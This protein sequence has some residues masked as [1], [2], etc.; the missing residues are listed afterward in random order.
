MTKI[1]RIGNAVLG[2]IAL[3]IGVSSVQAQNGIEPRYEK[4]NADRKSIEV[5]G[6][7]SDW[8]GVPFISPLFMASDSRE[9]G[10][11]NKEIGGEVYSQFAEFAGGTWSG[12]DDH[13]TS[14]A[15]AWDHKG[16]Y[17]GIIVKDDEHEH[18][19]NNAWNGDGVQMGLTDP[20]RETVTHLYN[21]A[22]KD[23]YESGKVY[24]NGEAGSIADKE[25]GP[26]NYKVAMVRHDDTKTT[27]YEAL[28]T[29]DSFGFTEFAVG[30]QFGFGVCVND[31][32]KDTAG[33]KGWSGWGPHMIVFGKTAPD[34]A[35]VTLTGKE[36][37]GLFSSDFEDGEVPDGSSTAGVAEVLDGAMHITEAANG[38]NGGWTIDDFTDGATFTEFELSFR[39]H[40]TDSACCGD[41]D[42]TT[43]GHRPADGMSISIGNDLPDLANPAEEG[44]GEGI[45]ICFDTWDSGGGEAPAIDFFS[46]AGVDLQ[47]RQKFNGVTTATEDEKFKDEDGDYVWLWTQGEWADVKI[48]VLDGLLTVNYKGHD[49]ISGVSV[50]FDPLEGPSWL[51]AARTGGAN[52]THWID[53]LKIS[54]YASSGPLV[55]GFNTDAAGFS[56]SLT[57]ADGNGVV[58]DSVGVTLDG[59]AVDASASKADGVTTIKYASAAPFAQGSTHALALTYTDE[60]GNTKTVPLDFTVAPYALI[61]AG[62][63]ADAS[64]KGGSGFLVYATQVSTG[65]GVGN[66]H[67]NSWALAE[68]QI[69]GGFIDPDTEEPYLN[70]ADVDS[71]EGWSYFPEIVQVVNQNQDAPAEV[72]NFK[73]SN[74]YE[75]EPLTGIPGWGDSTDGVASEYIALLDLARGAYKLGV[76]SDDGF[77]A[78]IGANFGDLLAQQIGV[79]DG[80]RGSSDTVFEIFVD[81]PG[82]YPFRVSWW[83]GGGGA[84]IEI[85]SY[86]GGKKTLI[87]DPDVDGSIKAYTIKGAVVDES[88]TVRATTGRAKMIS[89]SPNAGDKLVKSSAIEVVI[90]NE[91]TSVK[92]DTVVVTLNGEAVEASVSKDGNLVTI[93]Y[94]PDGGLPV[95]LHTVGVSFEESNGAARGTEW[96]FN[97]PGVYKRD[98]DVPTEAQGG[99]TV[100]EYHGIGTTSIA[101]LM[102]ADKFPDSPDVSAIAPYFEW[103]QS[104]DI[105]VN[106]VG[107]V[108]DN[109]GWHLMGYIHPP[110]TGEYSFAVATDDNSQ[111]WLSTDS[112]PA[113]AVQ[114]TQE[115]TWQG[116]RNYQPTGDETTSA[117]VFLEAGK[118]YF[119][120]CFAKEGG[121]GDNMAVAW[122][123]PEDGPTDVD[124]GSLPISGE[125][126]SPFTWAGPETPA[127]GGVSPSGV[128]GSTDY[129][130]KVIISN[131]QSVKM[132]SFT[133]LDINGVSA[134]DSAET[135]SSGISS[136]I[137]ADGS[138]DAATE[139]NVSVS[140]ENSDGS[141]GSTSWS[142]MTAPHSE[143]SLYIETEDFNY[144][145]GEW[146][147]FEDTAGGGA[148]DGLEM[149]TDIDYHN[150]GNSSPL[151]RVSDD[152]HPGMADSM[153]DSNRGD[154]DMDIDFKMGW[155]D[156]GDWYN[157]TRDFPAKETYYNVIGRFSSGGAAVNNKL[158]IVSGDT[159]TVD[160]TTTD[161]GVFQGPATGGWDTMKFF[162]MTDSAGSLAVVKIGGETT[163]RLTKVSGNMDTQYLVF[164]PSAIQEYPPLL[165][166]YG[167]QGMSESAVT[168]TATFA[169]RELPLKSASVTVNGAAVDATVDVT[170]DG[171]SISAAADLAV[172]ANAD[173]VLTWVDSNGGESSHSWSF[174]VGPYS[175]DN[176]FVEAEDFNYDGGAH[177][178]EAS[179]GVKGLYDGISAVA[180][181]DYHNAD[182][183]T[184]ADDYRKGEDPNNSMAAHNDAGGIGVGAR[185][186]FDVATDYKIG[187]AAKGDWFTYTRDF[188]KG[189]Y[190]VFTRVSHG[191]AN[192]TIGGE[193]HF[194]SGSD[195]KDQTLTEIG[196]ARG[197]APGGWATMTFVQFTTGD[198][199]TRVALDGEQTIR[200]TMHSGDFQYLMLRPV[201]AEANVGDVAPEVPTISVVRNDNGT[202]TVTFTGKLQTAPTVNGPWQ[203]AGA[204]SPLTIPADAAQQ[205]GRASSE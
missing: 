197:P 28:F 187:W 170:D 39:L 67:G 9:T 173:V 159:T 79:F 106:P 61:D 53:D 18:A 149:V 150:A 70:E 192:E 3:L 42:D 122:S 125:F 181:V 54:I 155:N 156:D 24:K 78:T 167:P 75:D 10:K 97:V 129:T 1:N 40:M 20:E 145:G 19:A 193:L 85:F 48:S 189:V 25:K 99:L 50:S 91:G 165:G 205:Y 113:N 37:L 68:K 130:V 47:A 137:S 71:F 63:I 92:Q 198:E 204:P 35:L 30:Q 188:P 146:M 123:T 114:L 166:S 62:S 141:T 8:S 46:G 72:G 191:N 81:K 16:L 64:Q 203:D 176:F 23:G 180:D 4:Y 65:Q 74:G 157:Y 147:T 133:S 154:F 120:E 34:A 77:S 168:I 29:P 101:V 144:D 121:G 76:N 102:A 140:W 199:P 152:N 45:R 109:Y 111:L 60:D 201:D 160:Q 163:V 12:S 179:D 98:G 124:A 131:G 169:N 5:D 164:V 80:G 84:N 56:I 82:L 128:T 69:A 135:T 126:L 175:T 90:Q 93:S 200:Y 41:A 107:N 83:E 36:V 95:G 110:E 136:S 27:I 104:G 51:F 86:V 6:D 194:V 185:A 184:T 182:G 43:A 52:E 15:V 115:S 32:D 112:D 87:N 177:M 151:Y 186:G 73:A 59:D 14:I 195:S 174:V 127:L 26:G 66:L 178:A 153:W 44:A 196:I 138:A 2:A 139:V 49:V 116:V 132:A 117:P 89:I 183:A 13:T 172:G 161:V 7:L 143:D 38:Q 11:G 134:L 171:G 162:P 190:E 158:S 96:S 94:A 33:Q 21:Y 148:Y 108:R 103:P 58:L 119:I 118:V 142:F 31:G 202:I 55:S 100:R 22:I 105:N 88:T 17:L 57:D